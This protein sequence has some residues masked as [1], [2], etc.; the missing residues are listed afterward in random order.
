L[1]INYSTNKYFNKRFHR[2]RW[3]SVVAA[4]GANV[5][6]FYILA[7]ARTKPSLTYP[8]DHDML[9]IVAV[10]LFIP[11]DIEQAGEKTIPDAVPLPSEPMPVTSI[12]PVEEIVPSFVA[13]LTEKIP[14][15]RLNLKGLP[16]AIADAAF[17]QPAK[18]MPSVGLGKPLSTRKVDRVPSKIAGAPPHYP[19]WARRDRLEAVVVL[20]FIVSEEGIA[21]DIRI[22]D[23]EG[24]E[25]FGRLA[26]DA[27][28]QWRFT[29]AIK[30]GRPV[31]C[32]CFQKISFRLNR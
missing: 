7:L 11:S 14:D 26:I 5:F 29:P 24:D 1:D 9:R 6:M 31:P 16:V 17:L 12:Q 21:R 2:L 25:R 18:T 28:A 3:L 22:H 20:R 27:I 4:I 30:S 15:I 8:A 23:I 19:L 10:D 13:D 32:W